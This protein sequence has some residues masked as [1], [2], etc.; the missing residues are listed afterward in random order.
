MPHL[1]PTWRAGW[2]HFLQ[3]L[4]VNV[5]CTAVCTCGAA[6]TATEQQKQGHCFPGH[7]RR[8]VRWPTPST[9][10]ARGLCGR[11]TPAP[12]R[13]HRTANKAEHAGTVATKHTARPRRKFCPEYLRISRITKATV[14][15][16]RSKILCTGGS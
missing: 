12:V 15:I 11:S 6:F 4:P 13:L 16:F 1:H 10:R 5:V 8:S 14:E 9:Q 2:I 3:P 7:S